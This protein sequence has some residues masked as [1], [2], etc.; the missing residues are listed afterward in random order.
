MKSIYIAVLMSIVTC[1]FYEGKAQKYHDFGFNANYEIEVK[2]K[3]GDVL[4][5]PWTGGINSGQ[6][7]T[8]DIN[9][10][11]YADLVLFDRH[12]N[13]ILPF[14][15]DGIMGFD[16]WSYAPQYAHDFPPFHHW[17]M[18]R[19]YDNDGKKDAFSYSLGGMEV[20]KNISKPGDVKFKLEVTPYLTSLQGAMHTNI[21]VTDV[22]YPGICDLDGDG[23][24]DILTFWGLG[25]FVE[26]HLNKAAERGGKNGFLDYEKVETCWG[27]FAENEESNVVYM[28]TCWHDKGDIRGNEKHT[29]STFFLFDKDGDGDQDLAL[30]DVDYPGLVLL[31]NGGTSQQALITGQTNNFPNDE[32]PVKLHSFPL[33]EKMDLN[34]DGKQDLVVTTFE[35]SLVKSDP[36]ESLWLY[37]NRGDELPDYSLVTHDFL[38][39][40]MIDVGAGATPLFFDANG[41]GVTDL[42]VGNY[43]YLDTA[44]F[45]PTYALICE[46]I[47]TLTLF[48]NEGSEQ[49]PRYRLSDRDYAGLGVLKKQALHPAAADL[50]GD[51]DDDLLVGERNGKLL[52]LRNIASPGSVAQYVLVEE[53]FQGI[54]VG[55]FSV[56]Q[57]IDMD[58]D[59]LPDLVCGNKRGTIWYY[60]NEG[61]VDEPVFVYQTD[62]LGKVSVRD[63]LVSLNGYSTPCFFRDK[64][65][66][67]RLFVGSESGSISYYRKIDG[68]LDDRF[69]LAEKRLLEMYEGIR[70]AITVA[71]LDDDNYPEMVVGNYCG[72][73]KWYEGVEPPVIGLIDVDKETALRL[74][75]NP[76]H[77][78]I[79]L[80]GDFSGS[81]FYS[82]FNLQGVMMMKGVVLPNGTLDISTLPAGYYFMQCYGYVAQKNEQVTL[83]F[84]L[85]H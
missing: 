18:F 78:K 20:Y 49:N 48:V 58:K 84:V 15:N 30:G 39:H 56:P 16:T 28:D 3:L 60:K 55:D 34:N 81:V 22:D 50:D 26:M 46:Y 72:G 45:S 36:K 64:N 14:I 74:F 9:G 25:S 43:G 61:T 75:P 68:A 24:L 42:L 59:G 70:S 10:D 80:Q 6:L 31:E 44:Y 23:D 37:E 19:D 21:L 35:P 67:L 63:P 85:L 77:G 53:Q 82:I 51:G 54:D 32:E 38:Q 69:E 8:L 17:V 4:P 47:S 83:P 52:F 7:A 79:T 65:D 41:D 13:R 73:L 1:F 33:A 2:N 12:G 29:G 11:D 62:S 66:S 40:D 5:F 27:R 57:I 76:S 71:R